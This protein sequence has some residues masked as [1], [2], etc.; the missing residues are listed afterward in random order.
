MTFAVSVFHA[1]S[2]QWVCQLIYHPWK[3]KGYGLSDGKAVKGFGVH[4]GRRYLL[5]A[6][7]GYVCH[8]IQFTILIPH[9]QYW[10]RLFAL[11]SHLIWFEHNNLFEMG[12]WAQRKRASVIDCQ[13]STTIELEESGVLLAKLEHKWE[14]QVKSQLVSAPCKQ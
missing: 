5:Y 1:F 10:R 9:L 13:L 12:H 2:H 6:Q 7:L 11:D 4:L 14:A 3:C 8:F